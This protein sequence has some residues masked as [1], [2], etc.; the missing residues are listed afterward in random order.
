[1]VS[2]WMRKIMT[3]SIDY[4]RSLNRNLMEQQAN[5]LQATTSQGWQNIRQDLM[6]KGLIAK[7]YVDDIQ[8]NMMDSLY[9]RIDDVSDKYHSVKDNLL[10]RIR[11]TPLYRDNVPQYAFQ[12]Y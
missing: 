4:A 11:E 10:N 8:N 2:D 3:P 1:M 9:S 7:L 5:Y 12:R 6:K